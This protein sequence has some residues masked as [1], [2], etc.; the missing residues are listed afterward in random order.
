MELSCEIHSHI[1]VGKERYEKHYNHDYTRG[2]TLLPIDISKYRK[3]AGFITN[4]P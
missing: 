2:L 3:W 4:I 1:L